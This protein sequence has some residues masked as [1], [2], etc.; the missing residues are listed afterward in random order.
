MDYNNKRKRVGKNLKKV[1]VIFG[2]RFLLQFTEFLI[3]SRED[4]YLVQDLRQLKE[5]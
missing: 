4:L 1:L 2:E 3:T 5:V